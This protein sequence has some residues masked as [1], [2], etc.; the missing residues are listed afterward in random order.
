MGQRGYLS[1]RKSGGVEVTVASGQKLDGAQ[2]PGE[3]V[4]MARPDSPPPPLSRRDRRKQETIDDIKA[5]ARRQL[6]DGGPAAISLRAIARDLGMT[7]SAVHYYFPSRRALLD[8][9]AADGFRD[10]AGSMAEAA[11]AAEPESL[12]RL[13]A[14]GRGYVGFALANRGVFQLIFRRDLLDPADPALIEASLGAFEDLV[15]LVRACQADGWQA[16][17]DSRLLAGSLWAAVQGIA[18]LWLWGAL[19]VVTHATS[20]DACLATT[21]QLLMLVNEGNP[22]EGN[23]IPTAHRRR[24]PSPS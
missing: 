19:Q 20:V 1:A 7:A 5:T 14:A 10:L 17:A 15:D 22:H 13:T 8:S 2:N 21:F 24:G 6:A 3:G 11:E 18:E 9:V 16:E 12:D 23:V 4:V